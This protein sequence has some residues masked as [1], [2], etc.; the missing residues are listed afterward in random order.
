VLRSVLFGGSRSL[1]GRWAGLVRGVVAACVSSSVPAFSVGCASGGD[2]LA[3]SALVGLG[4]APR[5]SVFAVGDASGA[6]FAGAV[7]AVPVVLSAA[8][9]GASVSWWAGGGP[10]VPLGVRLAVRSRVALCP[11]GSPVQAACWF[12]AS[13]ASVGSLAA[14]RAAALA[15][16]SVVVFCCGWASEELPLLFSRGGR[17]VPVV[18]GPFL[19]GFV[20]VPARCPVPSWALAPE[21]AGPGVVPSAVFA[22]CGLPGVPLG[23]LLAPRVAG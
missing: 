2:A 10:A 4:A 5:V 3:L 18:A 17:W 6:G 7:S 13:P 22:G 9:A 1:P 15:G 14:A 8:A 21:A 19:G 16:V 20:W 12:L 11:G 23:G